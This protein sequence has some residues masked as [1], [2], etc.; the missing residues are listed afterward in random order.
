MCDQVLQHKESERLRERMLFPK[1]RKGPDINSTFGKQYKL[2]NHAIYRTAESL[3]PKGQKI[4]NAREM[5]SVNMLNYVFQ[6]GKVPSLTFA[7][8]AKY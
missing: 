3:E 5:T 6:Q 1:K 7:L 2:C 8:H 4:N